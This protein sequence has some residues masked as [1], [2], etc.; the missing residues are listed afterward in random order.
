MDTLSEHIVGCPY[1]GESFAILVD[2]EDVGHAYIEDCQVCCR[3]MTVLVTVATEG[4]F[5][6]ELLD[7][8]SAF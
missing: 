4:G 2:P 1:C 6:V 8:N 3:P 7:E 5:R